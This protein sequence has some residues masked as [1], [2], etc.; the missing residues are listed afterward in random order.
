[1]KRLADEPQQHGHNAATFFAMD[2]AVALLLGS[3]CE[4]DDV[5]SLVARLLQLCRRARRQLWDY[6][7]TPSRVV[8]TKGWTCACGLYTQI[9]QRVARCVAG[10]RQKL[11]LGASPPEFDCLYPCFVPFPTTMGFAVYTPARL[12]AHPGDVLKNLR[13]TKLVLRPTT[14]RLIAGC[15]IGSVHQQCMVVDENVVLHAWYLLADALCAAYDAEA[16]DEHR[17][18]WDPRWATRG[19][20]LDLFMCAL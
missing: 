12:V 9:A 8:Y 20:D 19:E 1:M 10:G 14:R 16:L 2:C 13:A 5:I 15:D 17:Q 11:L 18:K 7:R 6:F 3:Q 4:G